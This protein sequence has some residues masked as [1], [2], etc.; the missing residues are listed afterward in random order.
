MESVREP[1]LS[2]HSERSEEVRSEYSDLTARFLVACGSPES[3]VIPAKAGILLSPDLLQ[4][5]PAFAGTTA[6]IFV[7]SGGREAHGN[8]S[9][10]HA[11]RGSHTDSL[12]MEP[13][14]ATSCHLSTVENNSVNGIL[15]ATLCR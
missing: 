1:H 13:D 11:K 10:R 9:K 7:A 15:T 14:E 3:H 5:V 2:C 4:W 12:T 6:P 8:S